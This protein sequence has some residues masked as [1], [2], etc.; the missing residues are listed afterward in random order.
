MANTDGELIAYLKTVELKKL[1]IATPIASVKAV[2]RM[3]VAG[4]ELYCLSVVEDYI[5]T[6]HYYD[7]RDIPEHTE[8]TNM[9]KSLLV[10][11]Q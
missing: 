7:K 6:D 3:H 1:V 8:I 10:K 11:W 5:S 4:D 2:D 9:L